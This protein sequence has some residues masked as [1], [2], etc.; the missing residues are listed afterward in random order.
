MNII[1]RV[2]ITLSVFFIL[3]LQA[4][5]VSVTVTPLAGDVW[6][7][8]QPQAVR[9]QQLLG[10]LQAK[11][12]DA[13]WSQL[14]L[15]S[16]HPKR[17]ALEAE[18]TQVLSDLHT[19]GQYW[20]RKGK[21]GLLRSTS[22]LSTQLKNLPLTVSLPVNFNYDQV[23]INAND[24]PLLTE[25]YQLAIHPRA[26]FV[27]VQGLVRLPGKRPFV[28]SA[29]AYDY[30]RRLSL[31][32]GANGK[33]LWII[34]PDGEVMTSPIDAFSP[35][36]VGVAPGATLY[37]GFKALPAEFADLNQRIITLFANREF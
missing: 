36:F 2:F 32:P 29:F 12:I 13:R 6:Q 33:K 22:A 31:L 18:R 4:N 21:Q 30:G 11:G 15:P 5:S 37:V 35:E 9:W 14:S 8:Q 7:W 20:A 26:T 28:D 3:P 23:R 25:H 24:N 1:S 10:Q 34:Q 19:L 27:H 17:V 16:S